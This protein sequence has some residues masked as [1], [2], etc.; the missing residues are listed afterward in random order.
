M[1]QPAEGGENPVSAGGLY[2]RLE[3]IER[4]LAQHDDLIGHPAAAYPDWTKNTLDTGLYRLSV[5]TE[6]RD[7]VYGSSPD[8]F[9]PIAFYQ[10]EP[11]FYATMYTLKYRTSNDLRDTYTSV[12]TGKS[13]TPVDPTGWP[14]EAIY[15]M[16]GA[17]SCAWAYL[18]TIIGSHTEHTFLTAAGMKTTGNEARTKMQIALTNVQEVPVT[19]TG[20]AHE[21]SISWLKYV[22]T[23]DAQYELRS[24]T[25]SNLLQID[26]ETTKLID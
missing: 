4:R 22:P 25:L 12:N 21:L 18:R 26:P 14:I 6:A 11:Q 8:S 7:S 17:Q 23:I 16:N 19:N 20:E 2:E 5:A 10:A 15:F 3:A 13:S 24:A 9:V 1:G